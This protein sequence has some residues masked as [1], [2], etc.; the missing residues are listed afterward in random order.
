MFVSE[1]RNP[2]QNEGSRA[3]TQTA[4]QRSGRR[5][6]TASESYFSHTFN[7]NTPF[8]PRWDDA[9]RGS[10]WVLLSLTDRT[11]GDAIFGLLLTRREGTAEEQPVENNFVL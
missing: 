2:G 1:T 5:T 3:R 11:G 9:R 8:S 7:K 6:T 10:G 4:S